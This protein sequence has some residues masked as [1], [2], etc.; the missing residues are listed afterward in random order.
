MKEYRQY[1]NIYVIYYIECMINNKGYIGQ[2]KNAYRRII[3]YKCSKRCTRPIELAIQKY[4]W[5]KFHL[6]IIEVYATQ[7][8]VDQAEIYWIDKLNLRNPKYGYNISAGG[9]FCPEKMTKTKQN[10]GTNSSHAKFTNTMISSIRNQFL[11]CKYTVGQLA[12]QYKLAPSNMRKIVFNKTYIDNKYQT[13]LTDNFI[14]NYEL[15]I[16]THS[17]GDKNHNSKFNKIQVYNMRQ[18]FITGLYSVNKIAK[19]YNSTIKTINLILYNIS[20][21]DPNYMVPDLLLQRQAINR[22]K[23][24][25]RTKL[26]NDDINSIRQNFASFNFT[27]K[28]LSEIYKVSAVSILSIIKN[29]SHFNPQYQLTKDI[30]D[31][32]IKNIEIIV[33]NKISQSRKQQGKNN[34]KE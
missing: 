2:S 28:E 11:T 24:K 16:T 30:W 34:K 5:E 14:K 15:L 27:I 10:V 20:Y 17:N 6:T 7:A 18:K 23:Y 21:Y 26:T 3:S 4:G 22:N 25:N 32:Y 19:E 29:K 13:Q 8:E 1:K 33:S 31:K 12:S 9:N